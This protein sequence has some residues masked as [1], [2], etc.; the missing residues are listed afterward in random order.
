MA[1]SINSLGIGSGVLTSDLIEKLRG[2]DESVLIKPL[3]S[4][5]SLSNQ[6]E[7]AYKLLN[8]LMTS[9][10]SSASSLD[11]DNLYLSRAVSGN[12]DAITVTADSG[13]NVQAFNITDVNL[14]QADVWNSASSDMTN[15][16]SGKFTLD[17]GTD[18]F[19]IDYTS[20]STLESIKDAI[21]EEA[22][23]KVTASLLKVGESNY[24]L[25]ITAKD[26]NQAITFSDDNTDP[27]K[28]LSTALGLTNIQS[29]SAATFKYN[30]IEI[31]RDTNEI[32]DLI[33]G[34]NITL[35][36]NQD[37]TDIA[38]ID[39]SQNKTSISSEIALFVNG[40][41][42]LV[43][44]LT[45]MTSSDRDT[46]S[47]GVFNGESFVKGIS[48]DITNLITQVDA[49]GNSLMDYGIELDRNGVMSL[50]NVIF[51]DKFVE[52]AKGM[53]TFFS[54][55][56]ENDGIFTKL[57]DRLA[58]YTDSNKLLSNFS[59]LIDSEKKSL[60]SQ[61]DKQKATLTSRYD[62][63]TQKFI[64]YDSMI[65]RMNS[66][67]SSMQMMINAQYAEKK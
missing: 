13:S 17:I 3:E 10:K 14:A 20:T 67:F 6:K 56:S 31:S 58:Q 5:I 46:G 52:D 38:S 41:N 8:S 65:S 37:I 30:G 11:G 39:I 42:A 44:N 63:L 27:A 50:N 55:D 36:E 22:G 61:Y 59:D 43:T 34:V 60:T 19:D 35:N 18:S 4:K 57:N 48:R 49:K 29:A 12:T 23:S 26:T 16:G 47:L 28:S 66:Q 51:A 33:V 54:G 53:E 45:D 62:I 1:G 15:L 2:A 64:A 24:E 40:Y 32:S 9:F 7:D 25:V 21:N